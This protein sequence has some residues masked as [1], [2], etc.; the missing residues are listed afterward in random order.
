[1]NHCGSSTNYVTT[2]AYS[3]ST[4]IVSMPLR[5]LLSSDA[6]QTC[7]DSDQSSNAQNLVAY[8]SGSKLQISSSVRC[9]QSATP[10]PQEQQF[11][12]MGVPQGRYC[13]Q[14]RAPDTNKAKL[15]SSNCTKL[16]C[17]KTR[18]KNARLN[19]KNS[20]TPRTLRYIQ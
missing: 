8:K 13:H 12:D 4:Q 10:A 20:G 3:D 7:R 16:Y 18:N 14:L 5:K 1:M 6:S 15:L 11:C 2:V 17:C 19:I 9:I